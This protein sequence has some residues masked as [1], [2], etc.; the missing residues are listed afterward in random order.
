MDSVKASLGR[1]KA[2]LFCNPHNP[3]GKVFKRPEIEALALR[4]V[5]MELREES[6]DA[7]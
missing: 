6:D 5:V 2:L 4:R 3:V 1:S 7:R